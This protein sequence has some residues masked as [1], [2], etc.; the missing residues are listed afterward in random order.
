MP[1]ELLSA[2]YNTR[3]ASPEEGFNCYSLV[4]Y[5]RETYFHLPTPCLEILSF[6]QDVMSH[7]LMDQEKE[8]EMIS[9]PEPGD[10]VVMKSYGATFWHHCGV[11]MG[12]GQV[13]HAFGDNSNAGRVVFTPLVVLK[14]IFHDLGFARWRV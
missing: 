2:P 1:I 8:W 13:I 11:Y 10:L 9:E 3:G 4:C 14:R 12:Q 6:D 7:M 5:V